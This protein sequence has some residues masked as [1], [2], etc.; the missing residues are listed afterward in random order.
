MSTS[1]LTL[2][3]DPTGSASANLIQ[4]EAHAIGATGTRAF[5]V[6]YGLFFRDSVSVVD[7]ATGKTLTEGT[8]YY[9]TQMDLAASLQY[10][11]EL[12]SVII[13]TDT[14][15]SA[16]VTVSYQALGGVNSLNS[17]EAQT[18]INALNIDD[19]V[20]AWADVTNKPK[21]YPP[22]AHYHQ[23]GDVFGLEYIVAAINRLAA[24]ITEGQGAAQN[25]LMQYAED[26]VAEM[27][28]IVA[29]G[30]ATLNAHFT[31]YTNPHKT[32]AAQIGAYTTEQT[33]AAIS[34]ET[35]SRQQ[36]DTAITSTLNTHIANHNNPHQ[37][38]PAQVGGM[39]QAQ[40]DAAMAAMSA[41]L[42]VNIQANETTQN[43]HITNYSNPHQVTA[44][45]IGTWTVSQITAA[46]SNSVGTIQ[47]QVNAYE[48]LLDSHLANTSNPHK[49][50]V[51]NIGTWTQ[52]AIQ[53]GIVN[54]YTAHVTN[55]AN[56]HQDVYSNIVTS[57]V[58]SSGVYSATTMST[59]ITNAY[60]SIIAQ[61]SSLNSTVSS[62]TGNFNNPH[63]DN[64]SNT[65]GAYTA[66]QL[67]YAISLLQGPGGSA[68]NAINY[69]A[70]IHN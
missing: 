5:P 10:G 47:N 27:A 67:A 33:T 69:L 28:G 12:D 43:A 32:T 20:V 66:G 60:N 4:N 31:D 51:T 35:L 62:H 54:P 55:T 17:Q 14:T 34:A 8:Q 48:A 41:A 64:V 49:D 29:T 57:N 21:D 38:T 7:V 39:T 56:P 50:T 45:Q 36:A 52:T 40:S 30:Q 19:A 13:I 11:Q 16:N 15:V 65:G 59:A 26:V 22:G 63:G 37:L 68:A 6:H 46:I 3:L 58:D 44:A 23:A 25:A 42:E 24:A 2:P 53:S 1:N 18:E 61:I 9:P 70:S